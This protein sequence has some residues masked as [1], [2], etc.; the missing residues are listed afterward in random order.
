MSTVPP[1]PSFRLDCATKHALAG[2]SK[3]LAWGL[4]DIRFNTVCLFPA[5]A[6]SSLVTGSAIKLGG[7]WT[8]S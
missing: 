5:S 4:Q 1:V 2:M 3:A 6:A 7:G 8:A